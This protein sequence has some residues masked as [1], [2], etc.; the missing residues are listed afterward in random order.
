MAVKPLVGFALRAWAD[1][2]ISR[3]DRACNMLAAAP[4]SKGTPG[5]P[6]SCRCDPLTRLVGALPGYECGSRRGCRW[7]RCSGGVHLPTSERLIERVTF[8]PIAV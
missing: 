4:L 6:D 8:Q 7:W 3:I 1:V 2:A 5:W